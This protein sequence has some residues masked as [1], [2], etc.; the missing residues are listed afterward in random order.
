MTSFDLYHLNAD[1]LAPLAGTTTWSIEPARCASPDG[2]DWATA[3]SAGV[4]I[5][6]R[7]LNSST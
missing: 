2:T 5:A 4:V 7:G 1:T 3:L 6:E